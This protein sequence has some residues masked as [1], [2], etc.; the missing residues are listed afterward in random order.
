VRSFFLLSCIN[1]KLDFHPPFDWLSLLAFLRHRAIPGVEFID[2]T[3]YLRTASVDGV[4]GWIQVEG[5]SNSLRLTVSPS[6]QA[7][8]GA[9]LPR[10]RDLFD[11]EARP[12]EIESH[13]GRDP[14]LRPI[15]GRQAGLRLPGAFEVFEM[16]VRAV[17]G[18]Q[19]S[20][21]AATTLA[22]RVARG[23]GEALETPHPALTRT[24]IV[25]STL[26]T[27]SSDEFRS[28]GLTGARAECLLAL[29]QAVASGR[30]Q[31]EPRNEVG[32]TIERLKELPGI[33]DWT[34]HYIAMRALRWPDAFPHADL[35]LRK[36]M[37]ESSPKRMLELAERWRPWRAYA[38]MH[39]W[40]SLEGGEP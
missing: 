12:R 22:G 17:L 29:A 30:I 20:V 6:L 24:T 1:L 38:V 21:R 15:V 26:A 8:S 10:V 25:A 11:L 9:L 35:G 39:L 33:G 36:A 18:Q 32:R 13:L 14:R 5:R 31:L 4:H 7:H 28:L 23:F 40:K 3:R 16:A 37:G 2:G 27:A 34:A 19:V